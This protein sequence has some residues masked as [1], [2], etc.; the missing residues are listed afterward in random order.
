MTNKIN[1]FQ[2]YT[3]LYTNLHVGVSLLLLDCKNFPHQIISVGGHTPH[4]HD[5]G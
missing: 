4:G 3:K 2:C 1:V 5:T